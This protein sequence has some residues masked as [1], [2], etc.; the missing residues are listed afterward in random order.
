M[1]ATR[2]QALELS[3]VF[4]QSLARR[5]HRPSQ[6]SVRSSGRVGSLDDLDGP[7]TMTL[8]GIAQFAAR[9]A[10]IGED[11]PQPW[12]PVADGL[13][14]R[15][16]SVAILHIGR[17]NKDEEHDAQRVSDDVALAPVDLFA[18]VVA[19]KTSAFGRLHALAVDNARCGTG[20]AAFQFTRAHDPQLVD[21][22][23]Q[24]AV[25]PSVA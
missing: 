20:L 9:I 15:R 16:G 7:V 4:S 10:S 5:R 22:L 14:Q 21:G 17:M 13:E 19:R 11:M 23:P 12:K 18:S 8:E 24:A 6:A 3:I 2:A 25:P 1:L